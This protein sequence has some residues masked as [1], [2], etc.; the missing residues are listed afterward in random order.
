MSTLHTSLE[1]K[2]GRQRIEAIIQKIKSGVLGE[3]SFD[4]MQKSYCIGIVDMVNS[5]KITAHLDNA[6]MCNYYRIYLNSMTEI[7]QEFGASI[8]KNVGDSLLYY[9][10]RTC[11]TEDKDSPKDVLECSLAMV[12]SCDEINKLMSEYRLPP[13]SYRVST[14]YGKLTIAKSLHSACDDVF[15]PTV[16]TCA[17]INGIAMANGIVIGGDLYQISRHFRDYEFHS[18]VG[19]SVGVRLDYPVYSLCRKKR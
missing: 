14:D 8:V 12:E 3:I 16:N 18:L 5:T 1:N 7:A 4:G 11:D 9:F 19:F 17:K 15:G 6:K 10:P 13:V 2:F